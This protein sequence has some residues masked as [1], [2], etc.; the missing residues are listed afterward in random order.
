MG[1]YFNT[2]ETIKMVARLNKHFGPSQGGGLIDKK[3]NKKAWFKKGGANRIPLKMSADKL[4]V[5]VDAMDDPN[6]DSQSRWE[7]W[8]DA[9]ATAPSQTLAPVPA[10]GTVAPPKS[11]PFNSVVDVEIAHLIF[12]GLADDP[13]CQEIVFVVLPGPEIA[14]DQPQTYGTS[15]GYSLIITVRTVPIPTLIAAK[16]RAA[17][18][19]LSRRKSAKKKK[20]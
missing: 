10:P 12:Q 2:V 6:G 9:L 13:A 4:K 15:T 14:V 18:V 3:R 5:V 7:F 1:M 11:G 19:R 8:L 16:K 20:V 17:L